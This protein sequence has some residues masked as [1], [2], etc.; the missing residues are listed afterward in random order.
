MLNGRASCIVIALWFLSSGL[1][2]VAQNDILWVCDPS[3][4]S[5]TYGGLIQGGIT[6]EDV[7]GDGEPEVLA[8]SGWQWLYC[9]N[10]FDGSIEWVFGP[11]YQRNL[12]SPQVADINGDG[13]IEVVLCDDKGGIWAVSGREGNE[14]WRYF[15]GRQT[16]TTPACWDVNGDGEI[17]V[18]VTSDSGVFCIDGVEG[19]AVWHA[20]TGPCGKSSP[21]IADIDG[22]GRWEV[23]AKSYGDTI[24]LNGSDGSLIWQAPISL[25][26][27]APN[28]APAIYDVNEDGLL[29]ILMCGGNNVTCLSGDGETVLWTHPNVGKTTSGLM[30]ADVN[31]D[32]RMEA[33]TT[34]YYDDG[35]LTCLDASSGELLWQFSWPG[36]LRYSNPAV[37]DVTGDGGADLV[38]GSLNGYLLTVEGKNGVLVSSLEVGDDVAS[39]PA[40]ADI[41]GDGLLEVIFGSH[42]GRV[43][44]TK[45]ATPSDPYEITWGI[46]HCDM[47]NSGVYN[48]SECVMTSLGIGFSLLICWRRQST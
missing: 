31:Q 35:F 16:R 36:L 9:I 40:V 39:S 41:N 32:G 38:V 43:Y 30:L 10:G 14:I 26:G 42:D 27:A 34:T 1:S 46:F 37:A 15:T 48:V 28:E 33:I 22:D 5:D 17:E 4:T 18:V 24:L 44:A 25:V 12:K 8:G 19:N 7:D 13:Q 23:V 11:T 29:D 6:V 45:T 20:D 21:V 3:E 2:V 47:R